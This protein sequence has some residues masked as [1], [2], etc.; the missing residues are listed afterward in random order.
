MRRF[1]CLLLLNIN[2]L[3]YHFLSRPCRKI[4]WI[5]NTLP[6]G[7]T[8]L[9]MLLI[10]IKILQNHAE[11]KS[12]ILNTLPNG[13]RLAREN[14]WLIYQISCRKIHGFWTPYH[15][16]FW[17]D[18]NIFLFTLKFNFSHLW[19]LESFFSFSQ[20]AALLCFAKLGGTSVEQR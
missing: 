12:W 2:Y 14:S 3:R 6:N 20:L 10:D 13:V 17:T 5:L 16:V 11:K 15:A 1:Q 9:T 7:V 19:R 18:W 4:L 8:H